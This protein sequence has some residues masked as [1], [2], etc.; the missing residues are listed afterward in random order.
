MALSRQAAAVSTLLRA[1]RSALER[2]GLAPTDRIVVGFSGGPDSLALLWSLHHLAQQGHGPQPI[3]V[4]VD[5]RLQPDS[6]AM[7]QRAVHLG[8]TLDLTVIV[9]QVEVSAWPEFHEGGVEAGARAARYAALA[10]VAREQ[11][12]TWIA[13]GHTRDDQAETLLLRLLRGAGL[14]GLAAMRPM[15]ELQLPLDPEH[16]DFG[17]IR[18]LRPLLDLRR[19]V[20]HAAL[21]LLGLE[22]IQD[23]TNELLAYERNAIRQR[24]IPVLEQLRP[25]VVD[26][27][28]QVAEQ[29][30]DDA[31]YLWTNAFEAYRRVAREDAT[32][33]VIERDRYRALHPALQRRI[34][35]LAVRTGQDPT[36]SLPRERLRALWHATLKGRP[37][38]RLELGRGL[39][40]LISYS[41]AVLGPADRIEDYLR[42]RF[43]L[44]LLQPGTVITL[45][46]AM[47]VQLENGWVLCVRQ[48]P[49]TGWFLR[50]RRPGDRLIRRQAVSPVRLQDWLVNHKVP[51]FLRDWL[52]L[53]AND[54]NIYWIAGLDS[55]HYE[56]P[57][58]TLVLD[59]KRSEEDRQVSEVVQTPAGELEQVLIDEATLQRRVAELGEEIAREYHGKRPVLIGVLTGAFVFMADLIRHMPIE[60]DI[61]F[62]AV[63]S[64]GQATVTS[65][66]VRIIKDLDRPIEGRDVLLVEDIIDSGL[67]LQYLLDVLQRR[68]PR[69]LRVVVLLR[70]QKPGATP[71]PV[72]WV[73]FEIP[74]EF[75][76]GYGLDAAGRF[77]NL[78]FIAVYRLRK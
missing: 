21:T 45:H 75:V 7:A 68:N 8:A 33:V 44:P 17:T 16:R 76:V 40:A 78:P 71:V 36:W 49:D 65:G 24:V 62:M 77:R 72:D 48:A 19:S 46:S 15:T 3:P 23:P 30:Q 53:L 20:V 43:G 32:F 2:A 39:G 5:H 63:S 60:L 64:Y 57:E 35:Q 50:T 29:L 52:P 13:V 58:G 61:D 25:R 26:I 38:M 47:T 73:G 22:P 11:G 6:G 18:L 56:S 31:S 4:H 74:D 67:T 70:K 1:V 69:S 12:T 66:V 28:A 42:Q 59:L 10:A 9:R 54:G 34:L 14:D 27:L 37:G 41:E 51:R 55:G